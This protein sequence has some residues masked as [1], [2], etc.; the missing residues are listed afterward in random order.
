MGRVDVLEGKG[1]GRKEKGGARANTRIIMV[2]LQ[3]SHVAPCVRR[4]RESTHGARALT[5]ARE[6]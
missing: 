3:S 4:R 1:E 2:S 6:G 5:P